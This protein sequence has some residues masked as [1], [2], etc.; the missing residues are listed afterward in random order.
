MNSIPTRPSWP[1]R[2]ILFYCV[3]SLFLFNASPSKALDEGTAVTVASC[4]KYPGF[5]EEGELLVKLLTA[6]N[7]TNMLNY[8]M[9]S[10][11][12]KGIVGDIRDATEWEIDVHEQNATK[13]RELI[14]G[15]LKK[16]SHVKILNVTTSGGD[17]PERSNSTKVKSASEIKTLGEGI[18]GSVVPPVPAVPKRSFAQRILH[19]MGL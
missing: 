17:G 14:A 7:M 10:D 3:S 4:K 2:R 18:P 15:A 13:A 6:N 5:G 9:A 16:G 11:G 19:F 8:L 12:H 1:L